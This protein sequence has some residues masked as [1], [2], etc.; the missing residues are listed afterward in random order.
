MSKERERHSKAFKPANAQTQKQPAPY[1]R[2]KGHT[3]HWQHA[4][5]SA[6][7]LIMV[8]YSSG[9]VQS[10]CVS[11]SGPQHGILT[12][13]PDPW[14]DGVMAAKPDFDVRWLDPTR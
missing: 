11:I 1:L 7:K 5:G 6:I 13:M 3:I 9:V 4:P 8:V 14:R 10:A 2:Y 12:I